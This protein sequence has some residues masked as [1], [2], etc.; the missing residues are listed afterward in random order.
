[1]QTCAKQSGNWPFPSVAPP[2]PTQMSAGK[3]K[4]RRRR[5]WI[6]T[7]SDP[8]I[9][10]ENRRKGEREK[11]R[12]DGVAEK[13]KQNEE[14]VAAAKALLQ[15]ERKWEN[16]E[17]CRDLQYYVRHELTRN[18]IKWSSNKNTI[19][20]ICKIICQFFCVGEVGHFLFHCASL[21]IVFCLG[22]RRKSVVTAPRG[23]GAKGLPPPLTQKAQRSEAGRS[24]NSGGS[25]LER[26][27]IVPR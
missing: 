3:E 4:R 24:N 12:K 10:R 5:R 8:G 25:N 17:D 16:H 11:E 26:G 2:P 19:A 13:K 18:T 1:M 7:S 20:A 22:H 23:F 14:R 15:K 6:M 27:E 21:S 9:K